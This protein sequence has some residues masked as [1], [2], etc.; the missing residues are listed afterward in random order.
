MKFKYVVIC[1]STQNIQEDFKIELQ[2]AFSDFKLSCAPFEIIQT[3]HAHRLK[4][5][6]GFNFFEIELFQQHLKKISVLFQIDIGLIPKNI[7]ETPKKLV[8][9]DM[10]S[11][12]I[13][14][15]VI[16]EM[17]QIHGVGEKIKLI[18]SRAMNGEINFN[19]ALKERMSL[20]KGFKRQQ[21]DEILK[22][23]RFTPGAEDFMLV[24]R[25]SGIKT[26][27]ASGGFEYFV[28]YV[29]EK[30]KIDEFFANQLD[31]QQD[32]LTGDLIGPIVNAQRKEEIVCELARRENLTMDQVMAIGDGANDIP[33]LLKAGLG[34][35]IH[36][37]EKVQQATYYH[38]NFGP[39][40]HA[41]SYMNHEA[42]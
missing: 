9:F 22:N 15:E 4:T 34:I 5:E 39:M 36:A 35:A 37:K 1:V 21:M 27:I 41:L 28:R 38:I 25:K 7:F 30:L 24:L 8:I 3:Q 11:T 29:G 42:L 40:T 19:Q 14:A 23:L 17:A 31:F 10:D 2:K 32:E 20:L 33:M 13:T 18:T 6:F 16:D 26:V 12:L